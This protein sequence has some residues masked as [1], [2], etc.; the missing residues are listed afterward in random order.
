MATTGS[1]E[2]KRVTATIP[3]GRV[4]TKRGRKIRYWIKKF[5]FQGTGR[6]GNYNAPEVLLFLR[7]AQC[8][9]GFFLTRIHRGQD[10]ENLILSSP[11]Q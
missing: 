7:K 1:K 10:G 3:V 5:R 2:R 8:I 11:S 4:D 9:V 6:R